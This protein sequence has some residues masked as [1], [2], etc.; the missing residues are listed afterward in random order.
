MHS[1]LL[2]CF[3][4]AFAHILYDLCTHPEY[5]EPMR[6]EVEGIIA[7]E[8]WTK[9]STVNMQKVDSFV[10]ESQRIAIGGRKF[11]SPA[12]QRACTYSDQ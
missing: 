9:V 3:A 2:H 10:K 11:S 8:G 5:I 6:K 7:S 1:I 12:A 4:Q